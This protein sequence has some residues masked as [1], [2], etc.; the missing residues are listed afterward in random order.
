MYT[1]AGSFVGFFGSNR[2][3]L[4][5]RILTELF[6]KRLLSREQAESMIRIVPEEYSN[7]DIDAEG[8]IYT[9]TVGRD[10]SRNEIKKLNPLGINILRARA[11]PAFPTDDF[12]DLKVLRIGS[13]VIDSRFIDVDVDENGFINGLDANRGRVFQYDQ[14]SNLLFAFG[15]L[16][17]QVG[18]FKQ[19]AALESYGDTVL[20]LDSRNADITIF[21]TSPFGETVRRAVKLHND[22]LYDQAVE[23]WSDVLAMNANYRLAAIGIG[24]ASLMSGDYADAL[25]NFRLGVDRGSYSQAY[26]YYRTAY[27]RDHFTAFASISAAVLILGWIVFVRKALYV[28][29]TGRPWPERQPRGIAEKLSLMTSVMIHPLDS[30]NEIKQ[31]KMGTPSLALGVVLLWFAA[32]TIR[33]QSTGFIFNYNNP[34]KLNVFIILVTTVVLFLL[35]TVSNW[36][37]ASMLDGEGTLSEIGIYSAYALQPFIISILLTTLMSNFITLEEQIFIKIIRYVGMCWSAALVIAG[38]KTLHQYSFAG[39]LLSS[40]LTVA[41]IGVMIF[42]FTL[43]FTMFQ[44]L[45]GFISGIISE[46]RYRL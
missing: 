12:G 42:L 4:S 10:D 40:A 32:T 26:R 31:R 30:F 18:L 45:G 21:R 27:L 39:T 38:H 8:F 19:A 9:T 37:V 22:G 44:E 46:V 24:K 43:A 5:L 14:E 1:P 11:D 2:V 36:C 7:V 29:I 6:W 33:R 15:G 34:E 35:W 20:V 25:S 17:E 13:Q 16:G 23:P 28:K 41:G 3:V